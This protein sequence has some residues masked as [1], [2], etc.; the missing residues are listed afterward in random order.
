MDL[1]SKIKISLLDF[2]DL[3]D[4]QAFIKKHWNEN[5]IFTKETTVFDW[6]HKGPK[7]YHYMVAK[8]NKRIVGIHGVIPLNHYDMSLKTDHI[9]IALWRVLEGV[10]IGIGL[11]IFKEILNH[12]KPT[13]IAGLPINPN[14][15]RFYESQKF[16]IIKLNHYVFFSTTMK[17]FKIAQVPKSIDL[18]Q[19][20][21]IN[22]DFENI[23]FEKLNSNSIHEFNL[24]PIF[25]YQTPKKS[26][27]YMINRYLTHPIYDYQVYAIFESK[28]LKCLCVLRPI[29]TNGREIF[30]IM[31]FIGENNSFPF[32]TP[33][34]SWLIKDRDLEYVDFYQYGIP[35]DIVK[36]AGFINRDEHPGLVTPG[37]FE[38]FSQKNLDISCAYYDSN[39]TKN[40]RIFKGDGDAD[41]PSQIN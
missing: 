39:N 40:V 19:T 28:K 15:A 25:N 6:Q 8:S 34:I 12:Y 2:N 32:I 23:S 20:L 21:T 31:D 24:G 16:Q 14:V 37:L 35:D 13:F 18:K 29:K 26:K 27:T 3:E 11:R 17:H 22:H 30:T 4:F 33:L 7:A 36:G 41:R 1:K 5:H 9:F 10:G 38:P